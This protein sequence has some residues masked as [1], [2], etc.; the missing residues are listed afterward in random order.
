[1]STFYSQHVASNTPGSGVASVNGLTG[2]LTLAA[3][4]NITLTPVGNTITI[5]STGGSGSPAGSNTQIQ[6]NNSGAFGASSNLIF[7]S[8]NTLLA[9][10]GLG[11]SALATQRVGSI[12]LTNPSS[13]NTTFGFFQEHASSTVNMGG[14]FNGRRA[15]GTSAAP[16]TVQAN[17]VIVQLGA[18]A[19]DGTTWQQQAN[20]RLFANET[21]TSIARGTFAGL[22]LT[23]NGTTTSKLGFIFGFGANG[24]TL[25]LQNF[26]ATANTILQWGGTTGYTL[27]LP[28][29]APTTAN[30]ALTYNGTNYVWQI[31]DAN[32]LQGT[33]VSATA[34]TSQQ[35][36]LYQVGPNAWVP[37]TIGGDLTPAITAGNFT[38]SKLQT[39]AVSATTPTNGQVLAY[40]SGSTQWEPTTSSSSGSSG[41]ANTFQLA[42]GSGGFSAATGVTYSNPSGSIRRIVFDGGAYV[43]TDGNVTGNVDISSTNATHLIGPGVIMSTSGAAFFGPP[44]SALDL[45]SQNNNKIM[46]RPDNSQAVEFWNQSGLQLDDGTPGNS[47]TIKPPASVTSSYT[48]KLPTTQGIGALI[49]DNSGNL[50][51]SG[52]TQNTQAGSTSGQAIFSQPFNGSAYKKVIIYADALLGTASYTFPTAFMQTPQIMTTNGPAAGIVTSLSTTA[53]TLTG[54]TTT[55]FIILEGY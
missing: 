1:M 19:Y 52:S 5:S 17:D 30:Q 22:S 38:V 9:V 49:N 11:S 29:A 4:S 2:A 54:A 24:A 10:G 26:A 33:S 23:Q 18:Q 36:L 20:L 15:R 37:T 7:D 55:G 25:G 3:G 8:T 39:V 43:G 47:V 40:N 48:I 53:V 32:K 16:T 6:F 28:D 50:A 35:V 51:W 44:S 31:P 14:I 45:R 12:Y 34:P 42:D 21:W 27:R 46:L 41:A 13:T